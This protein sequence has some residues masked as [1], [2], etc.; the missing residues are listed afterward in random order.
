MRKLDTDS[1]FQPIGVHL[2]R[3]SRYLLAEHSHPDECRKLFRWAVSYDARVDDGFPFGAI[4]LPQRQLRILKNPP[5]RIA[6]CII[7]YVRDKIKQ[8]PLALAALE[9]HRVDIRLDN[10][11]LSALQV[12]INH[13]KN[14][15]QLVFFVPQETPNRWW[16]ERSSAALLLS[17]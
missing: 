6:V 15:D 14:R 8:C 10:R 13:R 3:P 1:S 16:V 4:L 17:P 11:V 7:E 5:Y 2:I 12:T 9:A